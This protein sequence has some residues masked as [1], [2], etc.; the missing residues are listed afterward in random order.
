MLQRT[1]QEWKPRVVA[2]QTPSEAVRAS[3]KFPEL[4][5]NLYYSGEVSGQ[6]DETLKRLHNYYHQEGTRRLRMLAQWVP[7]FIYLGIALF[8]AFKV[9]EFYSGYFKQINQIM[10]Q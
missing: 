9:I 5:E 3:Q 6:L 1:V 2:G 7:R 4:F 10:G 8:V